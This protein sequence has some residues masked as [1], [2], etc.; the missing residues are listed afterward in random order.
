MSRQAGS[1]FGEFKAAPEI[2]Q[3]GPTAGAGYVLRV[4]PKVKVAEAATAKRPQRD[5]AEAGN[6]LG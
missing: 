1:M 4:R 3:N 6:L 2:R 5:S